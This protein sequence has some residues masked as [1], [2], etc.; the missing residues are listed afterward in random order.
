MKKLLGLL[1]L[2]MIMAANAEA[3]VR[4]PHLLSDNMVLQQQTDAR[5]WGWADAGK[6]V[7][8]TVSW[9]ND[10]YSAKADAQGKWKLAVKTPKASFTPLSITFDDGEK[11]TLNNILSGEV[12]VCAGQS[13]MEMP[14]K[15]FDNCPVEG[16]NQAVA[17]AIN[18]SGI[19]HAKIPSKMSM[20]PWEDADTEWID[21]N[22]QTVPDFSATGYFFARMVSRTLQIPVGLIEANKGGTRVESWLTADN[23]RKHTDESLDSLTNVKKYSWDF[24]RPLMWGNATFNPILNYTVKGIL[25][26]QGCSN[27]DDHRAQYA[28][29]L[30]LLVKQWRE[31]FA[32]GEIPFYYVEIAPYFQDEQHGGVDGVNGALLREQQY[33]ALSLIPNSQM[34][35]TNDAIYPAEVKNIHPAQKQKVGERLAFIALNETYQQT[36]FMHKS[37]SFKEMKVK[38]NEVE[39]ILKDTYRGL[40]PQADFEGFEIAGED[41]VFHK[42]DSS[43]SA[44]DWVS[45]MHI[46]ISSSEVEKPVAVRYCFRNFQLG[47]VKN[48]AGLPLIPFRTDN[49]DQ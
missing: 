18:S 33:K 29:R 8:V 49:W 4:L 28:E 36:S 30:A 35:C 21:C 44:W 13:N 43:R 39:L 19:R 48:Q 23:L 9:S 24:H 7:R 45:D 17:D 14:V 37:P 40:T 12:W 22:P 10:T 27:V 15:G 1:A 32:L 47:N 2:A 46:Y 3:K 31:Q 5:L 42:V 20:T 38:G 41:R 16:Y 25:F 11:T 34:V 26:Y 6:T